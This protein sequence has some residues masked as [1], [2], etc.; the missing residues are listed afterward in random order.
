MTKK[1]GTEKLRFVH[2]GL[3]RKRIEI[4]D[5]KVQQSLSVGLWSGMKVNSL[6]RESLFPP[7]A[8]AACR[9]L[10]ERL[11]YPIVKKLVVSL[12]SVGKR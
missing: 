8:Q 12:L 6:W 7:L 3:S 2:S 10:S 9:A 4:T 5:E 11:L 1:K